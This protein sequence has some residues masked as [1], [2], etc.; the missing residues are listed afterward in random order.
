M[1]HTM[2]DE[3]TIVIDE[4]APDDAQLMSMVDASMRQL[5]HRPKV[6][7][8]GDEHR[9]QMIR[10]LRA[11]VNGCGDQR[12]DNHVFVAADQ[13]SVSAGCF[14]QHQGEE[15]STTWSLYNQRDARTADLMRYM[16]Q[17][18][19]QQNDNNRVDISGL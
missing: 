13:V 17:T 15:Y 3:A 1:N 12:Q 4:T 5:N 9:H 19:S 2:M 11:F 6:P 8:L 16:K 7:I 18:K 10:N 14:F